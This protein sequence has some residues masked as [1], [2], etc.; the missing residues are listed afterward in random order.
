[1]LRLVLCSQT[2]D[3]MAKGLDNIAAILA[4]NHPLRKIQL[5]DIFYVFMCWGVGLSEVDFN[6]IIDLGKS[7]LIN[8]MALYAYYS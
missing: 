4:K 1:M 2:F 3:W 7:Y 8:G 6:T 5:T